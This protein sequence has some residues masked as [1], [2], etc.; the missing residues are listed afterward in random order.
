[1][2]SLCSPTILDH[3]FRRKLAARR[4]DRPLK[5]L[6]GRA[7]P[8]PNHKSASFEC[9]EARGLV[10]VVHVIQRHQSSHRFAVAQD[11][12]S[13]SVLSAVQKPRELILQNASADRYHGELGLLWPL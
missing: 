5:G 4:C 1:M 9:C 12:D 3:H 2:A 7:L 6:G 11:D 10:L 13:F 8:R